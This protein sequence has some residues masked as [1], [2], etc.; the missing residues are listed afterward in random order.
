MLIANR[1]FDR[2]R[3]DDSYRSDGSMEFVNAHE[4]AVEIRPTLV[5]RNAEECTRKFRELLIAGDKEI[6]VSKQHLYSGGK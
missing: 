2:E 6:D 5:K 4:R 1:K 3:I